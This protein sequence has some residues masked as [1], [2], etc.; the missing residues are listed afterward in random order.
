MAAMRLGLIFIALLQVS[1]GL[2][3]KAVADGPALVSVH[4][5]CHGIFCST[6]Q[7]DLTSIADAQKPTDPT[8]VTT[9]V[10]SEKRKEAEKIRTLARSDG[11][12]TVFVLVMD[13]VAKSATL[14]TIKVG[15][16]SDKVQ[17]PIPVPLLAGVECVTMDYISGNLAVTTVNGTLVTVTTAGAA[18][19][20]QVQLLSDGQAHG[21]LATTDGVDQLFVYV[22]ET[23]K[24]SPMW[25]LV[26]VNV[27]D[28]STK[29]SGGAPYF[30]G[31]DL[32]A[33]TAPFGIHFVESTKQI[34]AMVITILGLM[35][36]NFNPANA[37]S[38]VPIESTV[39]PV[40]YL[41][42]TGDDMQ[43]GLTFLDGTMFYAVLD[44]S[45]DADSERRATWI[46]ISLKKTEFQSSPKLPDSS[47][48][49]FVLLK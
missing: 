15:G 12:D 20:E 17:A 47:F 6:E 22:Y 38:F 8:V 23:K 32:G 11:A 4:S 41:D 42:Y 30:N 13:P 35:V 45:S 2:P 43:S 26:T 39:G 9:L 14:N 24:D 48:S 28:S 49:S 3:L 46:D 7:Y 34:G 31:E 33:N 29:L 36:G 5:K 44:Y 27:T 16:K 10:A 37:S 18:K 25:Y 40:I 19:L 21:K 1:T